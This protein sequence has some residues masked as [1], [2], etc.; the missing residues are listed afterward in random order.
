MPRHSVVRVV[1]VG[2]VSPTDGW[3][4][5]CGCVEEEGGDLLVSCGVGK[6]RTTRT[7]PD[8][9]LSRSRDS[10]AGPPTAWVPPFSS[11][12]NPSVERKG[13]GPTSLRR[14]EGHLM[15]FMG[16]VGNEL[17]EQG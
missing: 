8:F 4:M 10:P 17:R 3:V 9:R 11:L 5:W 15:G 14:G 16:M 1:V 7:R 2:A 13:G 12:P 6:V